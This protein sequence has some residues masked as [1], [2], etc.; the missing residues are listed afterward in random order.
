MACSHCVCKQVLVFFG[1]EE[2]NWIW[3]SPLSSSANDGG[4]WCSVFILPR[5]QLIIF[6]ATVL[7]ILMSPGVQKVPYLKPDR[8]PLG[9][10]SFWPSARAPTF[11]Q[12]TNGTPSSSSSSSSD[13]HR[14]YNIT[15]NMKASR[16]YSIFR[17]FWEYIF[18]FSF[19]RIVHIIFF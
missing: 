12:H 7:G 18:R 9:H 1:R 2:K 17:S 15:I 11:E 4:V 16:R 6:F 19:G 3:R 13:N 8:G 10:N 14:I 5:M